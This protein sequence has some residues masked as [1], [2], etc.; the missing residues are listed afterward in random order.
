MIVLD[1]SVPATTVTTE[2]TVISP[3]GQTKVVTTKVT[4]TAEDGEVVVTE[5]KHV[6]EYSAVN[7]D[8]GWF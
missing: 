2:E 3:E 4:T 6:T 5:T 1:F 8:A 7:G